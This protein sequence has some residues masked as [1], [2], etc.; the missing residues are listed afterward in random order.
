MINSMNQSI[1]KKL[2]DFKNKEIKKDD[3]NK[4]MLAN[5]CHILKTTTKIKEKNKEIQ[6]Q[7]YIEVKKSISKIK[8]YHGVINYSS[9]DLESKPIMQ[10]LLN[11]TLDCY[12]P[13]SE[14][15]FSTEIQFYKKDSDKCN[16][17]ESLLFKRTKKKEKENEEQEIEFE[18]PPILFIKT[19]KNLI[20]LKND[21]TTLKTRRNELF[22]L[23]EKDDNELFLKEDNDDQN[24][25]VIFFELMNSFDEDNKEEIENNNKEDI[26]LDFKK[27]ESSFYLDDIFT[28]QR[29][30]KRNSFDLYNN[31]SS[32]SNSTSFGSRANSN[33]ESKLSINKELYNNEFTSYMSF[34]CFNK[35]C[36]QMSIDYL[37]YMLVVYSNILNN[38]K[39]FIF[40][41]GQKF[42][43][44]MKSF[45]LKIGISSKKTYEKIIQPLINNKDDICNFEEFVKIFSHVLKLKDENSV[46]KYKFIMSLFRFVE[47]DINVKHLNIFFQLI[48]GKML[49]DSE[50]YDDLNRNLIQRYDR[51]YYNEVG[52][53]F[54]FRNILLILETFFDK[55]SS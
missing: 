24:N 26:V 25:N 37:R 29:I 30:S 8:S 19:E 27:I 11:P 4:Y 40:C 34:E 10:K 17:N 32:G 20:K 31:V 18:E 23:I 12:M 47:E 49:Y 44:M 48:K 6:K 39:K 46:L 36:Q 38:S 42:N 53:N 15:S 21:A 22:D 41:E 9:K 52:N 28:N 54:K 50:L 14:I 33:G 45:I 7:Q 1:I 43:N 5:L 3:L 16:F 35:Y 2:I 13:V 51:I 55:K